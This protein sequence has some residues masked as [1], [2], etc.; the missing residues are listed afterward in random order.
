MRTDKSNQSATEKVQFILLERAIHDIRGLVHSVYYNAECLAEDW[1][2]LPDID[3][4]FQLKSVAIAARRLKEFA[5]HFLDLSRIKAGKMLFEFDNIDLLQLIEQVIV[6]YKTVN[7]LNLSLQLAFAKTDFTE[8]LTYGDPINLKQV[9]RNLLNNAIKHSKKGTLIVKLTKA[10]N[11]SNEV[12]HVSL[13]DQGCG[14]AEHELKSIFEPFVQSRYNKQGGS[15]LGLT[16]CQ[17]IISAHH[18][19]IW[20]ENNLTTGATLHFTLP[21]L[22]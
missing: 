14:I 15:G 8:A 1:Q 6:E 18:G 12:W 13:S 16:V 3:R 4:K 17:E 7:L 2:K 5:D 19:K 9:L 11:G 22:T 21:V 10:K 20:A